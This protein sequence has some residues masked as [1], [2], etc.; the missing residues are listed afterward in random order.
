MKHGVMKSLI[1]NKTGDLGFGEACCM[2]FLLHLGRILYQAEA[3]HYNQSVWVCGLYS[4]MIKTSSD[5]DEALISCPGQPLSAVSYIYS[6]SGEKADSC[7]AGVVV[8][9]L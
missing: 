3:L 2:S 9:A 7:G 4:F 6:P 5:A 8:T 1:S